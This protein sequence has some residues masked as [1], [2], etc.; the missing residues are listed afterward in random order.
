M[1]KHNIPALL[2]RFNDG[3][4]YRQVTVEDIKPGAELTMF[5]IPND[6]PI[7]D[8]DKHLGELPLGCKT[9]IKIDR[10]PYNIPRTHVMYHCILPYADI[11]CFT[12]IE[13]MVAIDKTIDSGPFWF[14]IYLAPAEAAVAAT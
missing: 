14:T 4:R 7:Y 6:L 10:E 3:F 9:T 8:A 5:H 1:K 11:Q 12:T 13:D 2:Q